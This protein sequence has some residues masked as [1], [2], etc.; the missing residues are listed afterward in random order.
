MVVDTLKAYP[1]QR[2]DVTICTIA[3]ARIA[4]IIMPIEPANAVMKRA[5]LLVM[6]FDKREAQC[7]QKRHRVLR[8]GLATDGC[9]NIKMDLKISSYLTICQ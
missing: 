7:S 4:A 9:C 6:R 1:P 3:S 5:I 2:F 8:E